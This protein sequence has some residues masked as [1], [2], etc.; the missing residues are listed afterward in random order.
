MARQFTRANHLSI[1]SVVL[2]GTRR[3]FC[4]ELV[5]FLR[6]AAGGRDHWSEQRG[7]KNET[8]SHSTRQE[9]WSETPEPLQTST[10]DLGVNRSPEFSTFSAK[11][12]RTA[13]VEQKTMQMLC[14]R[15]C[16][17]N[18]DSLGEHTFTDIHSFHRKEALSLIAWLSNIHFTLHTFTLARLRRH[19]FPL[20]RELFQIIIVLFSSPCCSS[21]CNFYY[22][23]CRAN[24][25]SNNDSTTAAARNHGQSGYI[26]GDCIS[27][28]TLANRF[29]GDFSSFQ[30]IFFPSMQLTFS[31]DCWCA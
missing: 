9:L 22:K 16:R 13:E 31:A 29:K 15:P 18:V 1:W 24:F 8:T 17:W 12:S 14:L 27:K 20:P 28:V 21:D 11:D 5:L 30:L 23:N 26:K 6:H 7:K 2:A 4:L 19:L 10:P 3:L 25:L